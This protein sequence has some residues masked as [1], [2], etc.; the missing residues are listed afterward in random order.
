MLSLSWRSET[1]PAARSLVVPS[2]AA[3]RRLRSDL[4]VRFPE[5]MFPAQNTL[6]GRHCTPLGSYD[7]S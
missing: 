1:F 4:L 2:I 3:G 6:C 7:Y 5:E